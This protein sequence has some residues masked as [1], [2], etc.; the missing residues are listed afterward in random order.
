MSSSSK[1]GK[2]AVGM[3]S[4]AAAAVHVRSSQIPSDLARSSAA[5]FSAYSGPKQTLPDLPYDYNALEPV[6]SAET[7]TLH[8]SKHHNTYVTNLNKALDQLDDALNSGDVSSLIALQSAI[9]FNGGGHLNHTLFWQN[10]AAN[11][12][13]EPGPETAKAI[14][15]SPFRDL[16]TLQT[17]LSASTVAVQGSG[18]GWLGWNPASQTLEI[19]TCVN[20]DPL[21][22]TT[23]L[24]PLLGIDVWEHA[25]YVDYRNVRPEYVK[26]IWKII[27][28][29]TVEERL[30][31]AQ[32]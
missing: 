17:K 32:K 31:A 5:L 6:I 7:M 25:Y 23:G 3:I 12:G 28:W 27:H 29:P 19:A 14:A 16:E 15:A 22:A 26:N 9:K 30:V 20:Q 10:L 4:R 18:W 2:S 1:V 21:H 13:G 8:H 11:G 24:V